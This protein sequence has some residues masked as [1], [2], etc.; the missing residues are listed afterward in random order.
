MR[1]AL[2]LAK[3]F[4]FLA[5]CL[6]M[7]EVAMLAQDIRVEIEPTAQQARATMTDI[8]RLA[9]T[10]GGVSAQ[11]RGT[12]KAM[13]DAN[14]QTARNSADATGALNQ[15]LAKFGKALD[16]IDAT[17]SD[18]DRDGASITTAANGTISKVS[19]TLDDARPAVSNFTTAAKGAADAMNDPAIHQT[20]V[21]V[22]GVATNAN[23]ETALVVG[24]TRQAFAP[25]SKLWAVVNGIFKGTLGG[26]ELVFYLTK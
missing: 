23:T 7:Y 22:Q 13:K 20:L 9:E 4:T 10:A 25:R 14:E 2:Q 15:D 26:A 24:E 8:A 3:L 6:A 5:A 17:I 18:L 12:L 21:Q 11:L 19:A 16:N 1:Y